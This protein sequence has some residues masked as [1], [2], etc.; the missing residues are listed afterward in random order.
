LEEDVEMGVEVGTGAFAG[1]VDRVSCIGSRL[2]S[3]QFIA[4]L[5]SKF[6]EVLSS[7]CGGF[8]LVNVHGDA[9]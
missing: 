9:L 4:N 5:R 7:D 1:H 2:P 8:F 6:R 3:S